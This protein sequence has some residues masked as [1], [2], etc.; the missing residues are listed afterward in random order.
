MKIIKLTRSTTNK[1]NGFFKNNYI[2]NEHEQT[3]L[4]QKFKKQQ[5]YK[6]YKTN[7]NLTHVNKIETHYINLRI[8]KNTKR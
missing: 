6:K 8:T 7:S 2:P 3:W 5:T 1:Q 4:F